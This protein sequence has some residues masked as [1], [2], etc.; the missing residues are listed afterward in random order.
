MAYT[1]RKASLAIWHSLL[2]ILPLI[3]VDSKDLLSLY[4]AI[5]R[6]LKDEEK[7]ILK[8]Q[9]SSLMSN[10]VFSFRDKVVP[11]TINVFE[12]ILSLGIEPSDVALDIREG[13]LHAALLSIAAGSQTPRH[14]EANSFLQRPAPEH[15]SVRRE[16][17]LHWTL[18][19]GLM[20]TAIYILTNY[21]LE[22]IDFNYK[23]RGFT[24]WDYIHS[25]GGFLVNKEVVN[26]MGGGNNKE[27]HRGQ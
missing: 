22:N 25:H 4:I 17:H 24:C 23:C 14:L 27:S 7:N 18:Q 19:R 9:L 16:F 20:R 3:D 2:K 21:P 6:G 8:V 13:L 1:D 15:Y 26:H 10:R 5:A 11:D 12:H